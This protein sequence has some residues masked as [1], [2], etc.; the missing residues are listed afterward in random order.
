MLNKKSTA[1]LVIAKLCLKMRSEGFYSVGESRVYYAIYQAAKYL[2][3]KNNFDYK[4][5]KMND[6]RAKGQRDYAHGSISIALEYFLLSNGFNSQDDLRFIG[7]MYTTFRKLYNWRIKGDY[8]DD[9]ITKKILKE[10]IKRAE[11]FINELKK[12]NY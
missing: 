2:L 4:L 3:V 7:D 6:P 10:A 8:E 9:V 12:Y 5:F 11:K 1:N